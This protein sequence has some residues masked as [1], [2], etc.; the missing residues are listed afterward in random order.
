[1][2]IGFLKKIKNIL[3]AKIGEIRRCKRR[4]VRR[5]GEVDEDIKAGE[6]G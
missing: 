1:M 2:S 4:G 5:P 6:K 3:M